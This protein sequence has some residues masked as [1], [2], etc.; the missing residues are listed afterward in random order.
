MRITASFD[1][2]PKEDAYLAA[3]ME[4]AG[5]PTTFYWPANWRFYAHLNSWEGLSDA[6]ADAIAAKHEVGSHTIFH[7][8]LPRIPLNQAK[9]E[10][11][12]SRKMLQKRFNQPINSFCYPRGHAND[13]IR[14]LVRDAGYTHA[15][16]T[17]VGVISTAPVDPVWSHTTVHVGINREEYD[18]KDWLTYGLEWLDKAK[19]HK[20]HFHFWGHG[21]EL[22]KH[23]QWTNFEYFMREVAKAVKDTKARA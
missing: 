1:D 7:P 19:R 13:D 3:L 20:G 9:Q 11:T 18:G 4:N 6:Q 14:Q 21:W 16:T 10:I 15:R 17:I 12:E 2:A 5:V 23:N 22:T 8:R